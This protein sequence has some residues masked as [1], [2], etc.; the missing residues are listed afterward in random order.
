M[1]RDDATGDGLPAPTLVG[2]ARACAIQLPLHK[3]A[4]K[5]AP[6][7]PQ[8]KKSQAGWGLSGSLRLLPVLQ[9]WTPLVTAGTGG[10]ASCG[11]RQEGPCKREGKR[12]LS[13]PR[14]GHTWTPQAVGPGQ[15]LAPVSLGL[16]PT[17]CGGRQLGCSPAQLRCR[18]PFALGAWSGSVPPGRAGSLWPKDKLW[19]FGWLYLLYLCF[20]FFPVPGD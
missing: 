13:R 7:P 17:H 1:P 4:N 14:Q 3:M 16:L 18:K 15:R 5:M 10:A 19:N 12:H 8:E 6:P 9:L 2:K 11:V 20:S